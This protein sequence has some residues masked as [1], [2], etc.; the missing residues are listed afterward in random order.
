MNFKRFTSPPVLKRK[1]A[2]GG[3]KERETSLGAVEA[4]LGPF[5]SPDGPCL[6]GEKR[7][8]LGLG[9]RSPPPGRPARRS[10]GLEATART[11]NAP[12]PRTSSARLSALLEAELGAPVLA[13]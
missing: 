11:E 13:C 8:G 9:P 6:R 10:R 5:L 4:P 12:S 3:L 7:P 1:T 2:G